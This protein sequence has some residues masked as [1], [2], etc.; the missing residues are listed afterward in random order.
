MQFDKEITVKNYFDIHNFYSNIYGSDRTIIL[1][2]V[3]SFHEV[4]CTDDEGINLV[5]LAQQIDVTCTKKDKSKEVSRSYPR[6]L[7]FPIYV[8]KNYID[9]LIELNYTV[10]LI[11]QV[12]A[13]PNPKREITNIYSPATYI[14]K[15][16]NKSSF[17]VSIVIEKNCIGLSAYDLTTGDGAIYETYSKQNDLLSGLDDSLI[18]LDNYPPKEIILENNLKSDDI[19]VNLNNNEILKYLNIDPKITYKCNNPHVKKI[20]YQRSLLNKIYKSDSNI[21]IIEKLELTFLNWARTSLVM[22]LDYATH[23][24]P[25]L[26]ENLRVPKLF[27]NNKY[28]YLG[29]RALEQLDVISGLFPIINHTKTI[30]G[31]RFLNNQ[32][33]CPIINQ[34][35]LEN[36][37]NLIEELIKNNTQNS[38]VNYLEDIYDLDKLIRKLELNLI[39]PN[40]L[41]QIYISFYQ[42]NNMIKNNLIKSFNIENTNIDLINYIENKFIN[43]N[44]KDLN[45]NNYNETEESIYKPNVHKEIDIIKENIISV[46]DFIKNLII[47]LEKYI[48]DKVY[49]KKTDE[50]SKSLI[51]LKSN[52]RD[53]HYLIIT[54][55]RCE[56][57]KKNLSKVS[58]LKIGTIEIN[59]TDLEFNPL[60]KSSNVKITC[61]KIK[62]LSVDLVN[63]KSNLAKLIKEE[64]KK[65]MKEFYDKYG[66]DIYYWTKKIAFIDFIN[67]GALVAVEN[68]YSKPIIKIKNHSYFKT[69][70]L[71]HPI[72]EK[73]N[74]SI[75]YSPHDIELGFET[76]QDGILLYGINSSGKSTLMKSIGLNI[77]LA[78]IGYYTASTSFIFSPYEN[79]FTRINGNDNMFRG[80]SSFMVEMMELMAIM[81]R[82]NSKSLIIGDEISKGT[83][84]KSGNIIVCYMLET[85]A[86]SNSSFITATH[87]HKITSLESI[88]KLDRVK[89][90]HLKIT[91]DAN[92]DVI[93]YD[94]KLSDGQ[95]DSFYGLQVAKYLMKDKYFNERTNEILKEYDE[96]N[97][98]KT[99]RYNS[100]I[101]LDECYLCKGKDK[102]E[103]HH[104]V[105]QKDFENNINKN[106]F[107]LQKNDPSNIVV[108]CIHCH[109]KVDRN[110]IIIKGWKETSNGK[111]LDYEITN[112][113]K[114][115]TKMNEELEKYIKELQRQSIDPKIAKIKVKENYNKIISINT[116]TNVWLNK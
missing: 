93:I 64:F 91:Y 66:K 47:V 62:E 81:K 21:D 24:Q 58:K 84:E 108:L 35:E 19:L 97:T 114:K 70:E 105:W 82:N 37:Y 25:R 112:K 49:F 51:T 83:E 41:Y 30:I 72:V 52:D 5:D 89:I 12:T 109:D 71:R 22:L 46:N 36:R 106:K 94:R 65:D 43:D 103:S 96:S 104:I 101:Y 55:R 8:T 48:D 20:S 102:L 90:K 13:P 38:L 18:F 61:S 11:D 39:N 111:I 115:N 85:L 27:S 99:S 74:N 107:Y 29:N 57:M 40:E 110:E 79:L 88:K 10:V 98:I 1:M 4:Y 53:G 73:I 78:Q 86:K 68:H 63:Y 87:L 113:P 28:L 16:T 45:F 42:I 75:N 50:E 2:Q 23:H 95:G 116:I 76:K 77:I 26:L 69:K 56:L 92:N 54:N 100:T 44:I 31:K 15:K 6:M 60:P 32:L 80:L 14:D 33:T 7:G 3:G 67:S 59:I 9:K 17:L 34:S